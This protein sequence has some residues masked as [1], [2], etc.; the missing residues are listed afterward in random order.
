MIEVSCAIIRNEEGQILVV[1]RGGESD[2]PFKWEFPGGKIKH[3]ESG[4]NSV[5]RE[6]KEELG[7]KVVIFEGEPVVVHDYKI[8]KIALHPYICD[9]LDEPVLTEHINYQ[10]V[11][12]A[13]L[14]GIDLCE[15]DQKVAENLLGS[16]SPIDITSGE[17]DYDVSELRHQLKELVEKAFSAGAIELVAAKADDHNEAIDIL[18]EFASATSD[19]FAFRASWILTKICESDTALIDD[20][21]PRLTGLLKEATQNGIIRSWLKILSDSDVSKLDET[22]QGYLADYCFKL[23]GSGFSEIAQKVYSMA[24]LY[25]LSLI[26]P[27]LA[28]ELVT[29]IMLAAEEGSA[30]I[31]ARGQMVIA[32]LKKSGI[33]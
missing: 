19:R 21:A 6:V 12:S 2:H 4:E 1:Q 33:I 20:I 8:K 14:S 7:M 5:I 16:G 22:D 11:E 30:A 27:D 10:W 18:L 24:I 25:K 23:L 15:A 28:N 29:A 9:T 26:Y 13:D 32:D 31:K 3:G 17:P